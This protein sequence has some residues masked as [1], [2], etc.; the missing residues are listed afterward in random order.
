MHA[1]SNYEH[2]HWASNVRVHQWEGMAQEITGV[3]HSH[4]LLLLGVNGTSDA[5]TDSRHNDAGPQLL[6]AL[7]MVTAM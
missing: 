1:T 7:G 5:V 3:S 2:H 4:V 6:P